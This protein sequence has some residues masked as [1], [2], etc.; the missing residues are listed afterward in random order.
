MGPRGGRPPRP[1]LDRFDDAH[2]HPGLD[3]A[4]GEG[5]AISSLSEHV[6]ELMLEITDRLDALGVDV[7]DEPTRYTPPE[8]FAESHPR[9]A[10]FLRALA[11][12]QQLIE[13]LTA[14]LHAVDEAREDAID[15]LDTLATRKRSIPLVLTVE[16]AADFIEVHPETIRR[17]IRAK[18]LKAAKIGRDYRINRK[19]LSDWFVERGGAPLTEAAT[20]AAFAPTPSNIKQAS[21]TWLELQGL[22]LSPGNMQAIAAELDGYTGGA[23]GVP[24]LDYLD[25]LYE[26]ELLDGLSAD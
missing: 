25:S 6:Q 26:R 8:N 24:A 19:D 4:P 12:A 13:D 10:N 22:P 21:I 18:E 11:G 15:E 16:Q 5:D 14:K 1:P 17:S 7:G 9:T 20:G 3:G 23:L 2:A